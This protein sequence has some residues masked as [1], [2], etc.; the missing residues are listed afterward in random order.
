MRGHPDRT[1]PA[2]RRRAREAR[3]AEM[4]A[5]AVALRQDGQTLARVGQTLGISTSRAAQI[6]AKAARLAEPPRWFDGLPGRALNVLVAHG[7]IDLP[8]GEAARAM[9]KLSRRDLTAR[10]N[11]GKGAIGALSQ[12]LAGHGLAFVDDALKTETGGPKGRPSDSASPFAPGREAH[13]KCSIP[14]PLT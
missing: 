5:R 11:V 13:A 3:S 4:R 8:E 14:P 2:D 6:V 7:L 10:A 12:W 1:T 9:A